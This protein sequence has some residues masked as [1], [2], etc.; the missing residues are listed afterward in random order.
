M[1]TS[2]KSHHVTWKKPAMNGEGNCRQPL[3]ITFEPSKPEVIPIVAASALPSLR[4]D[5]STVNAVAA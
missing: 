3:R 5:P 4:V 2:N 1:H